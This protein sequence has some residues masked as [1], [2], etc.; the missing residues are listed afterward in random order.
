VTDPSAF[1]A[2][3]HG[4]LRLFAQEIGLS[5]ERAR[6]AAKGARAETE[7]DQKWREFS[8]CFGRGS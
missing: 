2:A 5:D 4:Q 7:D 8:E 1:P 3:R 6:E